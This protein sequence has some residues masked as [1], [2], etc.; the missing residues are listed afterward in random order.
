MTDLNNYSRKILRETAP[1]KGEQWYLVEYRFPNGSH[2]V[3][4]RSENALKA[5]PLGTEGLA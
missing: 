3:V 5:E 1:Y 4:E 2:F